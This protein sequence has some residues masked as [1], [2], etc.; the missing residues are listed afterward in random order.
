MAMEEEE[1]AAIARV[2]RLFPVTLSV[3][4]AEGGHHEDRHEED[5]AQRIKGDRKAAPGQK[6]GLLH[7]TGLAESENPNRDRDS[8]QASDHHEDGRDPLARRAFLLAQE[9]RQAAH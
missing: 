5:R 7:Q 3:E 1:L 2:F 9:T 6:P 4:S 8:D